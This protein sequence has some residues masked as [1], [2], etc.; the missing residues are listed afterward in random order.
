M[1]CTN[2]RA[3]GRDS[4]GIQGW[5]QESCH[6][7]ESK[8]EG[9]V[10]RT[11]KK[12]QWQSSCLRPSGLIP[13]EA[14]LS[15]K[16]TGVNTLDL[17]PSKVLLGFP[18][19]WTH[20]KQRAGESVDSILPGQGVMRRMD[21]WFG[22]VNRNSGWKSQVINRRGRWSQSLH[23]L[24]VLRFLNPHKLLTKVFYGISLN[25]WLGDKNCFYICPD[26]LLCI[27]EFVGFIQVKKAIP[28]I[29]NRMN[30]DTEMKKNI[31]LRNLRAGDLVQLD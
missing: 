20:W 26:V 15:G 31:C 24:I 1:G 6:H 19:G 16:E 7:P 11:Q 18:I 25:V 22:G 13:R 28:G 8:G 29:G 9:E 21:S 23:L 5:Q 10:S 2:S 30:K 17:T 4:T 12:G 3:V 14:N 27:K